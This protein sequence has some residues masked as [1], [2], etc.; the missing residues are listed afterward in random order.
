MSHPEEERLAR[1]LAPTLERLGLVVEDVKSVAAGSRRTLTVTVDLADAEATD[2]VSM[3]QIAEA[4]RAL[5]GTLDG[6]DVFGGKPFTLEV[7]S[8]G[9]TRDLE[10]R[11]HYTRV[12]GRKLALKTTDGHKLVARLRSVGP[13]EGGEFAL[14]LHDEKR[15]ELLSLPRSEVARARV[16]LE[17]K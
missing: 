8:P 15:D 7:T 10:E 11:R 13:D 3:E 1:E 17:F 6:L 16:E 5:D 4:T 9:A 2:P 14:D 12:V